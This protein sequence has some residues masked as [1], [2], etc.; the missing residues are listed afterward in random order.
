MSMTEPIRSGDDVASAE[1]AFAVLPAAAARIVEL[2]APGQALRV[3]V[4]AGGCSGFQYAFELVE[5]A[6]DDHIVT[7]GPARV[8]IDP[9]SLGLLA[10]SQLDYVDELIGAAFRVRNPNAVSGCG[11]GVSFAL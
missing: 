1:A 7:H 2:A 8:A 6:A 3:E 4:K 11:C 9:V 5:P 10:G